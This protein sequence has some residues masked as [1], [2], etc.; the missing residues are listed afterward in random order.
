MSLNTVAAAFA[1][2]DAG[3][4]VDGKIEERDEVGTVLASA[5]GE[6]ASLYRFGSPLFKTKPAGVNPAHFPMI[7]RNVA[8]GQLAI[9][10]GLRGWSTMI[11]SGDAA[12]AHALAR[13][14]E[15]VASGR[16]HT[17][18]V[19]AYEVLSPLCL[20][21][22]QSRRLRQGRTDGGLPIAVNDWVPVEGACFFIVESLQ[23]AR[24]RGRQP[25]ALLDRCQHGYSHGERGQGWAAMIDRF[26]SSGLPPSAS[27]SDA[28]Y[29]S[30]L[31]DTDGS[32]AH[33]HNVASFENAIERL[34]PIKAK[35]RT[36][37]LFGDARSV[38]PMYGVAMSCQALADGKASNALIA[39]L[40]DANAYA[41]FSLS[42]PAH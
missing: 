37:P 31:S 42:R 15:M 19:G 12:G 20:H 39:N 13:A 29:V 9:R 5:Q 11:A 40:T 16:T 36:R 8:C 35:V 21:R 4:L 30:C 24:A 1:M 38:N 23:H 14:A 41:L 10:F 22:W 3:L 18:L 7:A 26:L 32:R 34:C 27:G 25:Y 6:A 28:T 17:M 33:A 2:E